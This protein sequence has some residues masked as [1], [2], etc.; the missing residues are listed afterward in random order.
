MAGLVPGVVR[1]TPSL[2][3]LGYREATACTDSPLTPLGAILRGHEFH[4]SVWEIASPPSPAWR[5]EGPYLSEPAYI[6]HAE[7]GLVASYLH[8]PLA[9]RPALARR[10]AAALG[11]GQRSR[12]A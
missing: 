10:L 5:V 6:G 1:M 11:A 9:Q 7:R 2:A 4:F 8:I 12:L 3:A